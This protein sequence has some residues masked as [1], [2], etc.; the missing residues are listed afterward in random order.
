MPDVLPFQHHHWLVGDS[1]FVFS[2]PQNDN[3]CNWIE[4]FIESLPD[5]PS[6]W[7]LCP[8]V[9]VTVVPNTLKGPVLLTNLKWEKEF[10]ENGSSVIR[11]FFLLLYLLFVLF[12]VIN[13][14]HPPTLCKLHHPRGMRSEDNGQV[15]SQS[16]RTEVAKLF[17][18]GEQESASQLLFS[19]P[20][21][22]RTSGSRTSTAYGPIST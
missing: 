21:L 1:C 3:Y 17:R 12:N 13:H 22:S 11:F 16:V 15:G 10:R 4:L 9:G 5:H 20:L 14:W 18:W 7:L 2:C 8:M 19:S 6:V